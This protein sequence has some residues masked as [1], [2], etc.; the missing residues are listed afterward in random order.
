[1]HVSGERDGPDVVLRVRDTGVGIPENRLQAI[2]EYGIKTAGTQGENGH[3]IG[4][5]MVR[6]LCGALP[7]HQL[8]F[9]SEEG[10][11][12]EFTIVLPF[13]EA[14]LIVCG[15]TAAAPAPPSRTLEG[16]NVLLVENDDATRD[17][18]SLLLAMLGAGVVSASHIRGALSSS[19]QAGRQ[20]DL[21]L[22][23]FHL[24]SDETGAQVIS[25]VRS[26]WKALIPAIVVTADRSDAVSKA[27][28]GLVNVAILYK[29]L[30]QD[31]LLSAVARCL[32]PAADVAA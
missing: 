5:T 30:K 4:L 13:C 29:E 12:S 9:Y 32:Q 26:H 19:S 21:I 28:D 18:E 17:G 10:A 22:T 20:P 7:D 11:G 27:L 14:P 31:E 25:S 8:G 23:D 2:W 16:I 24:E 1:M 3:G 6:A 15:K